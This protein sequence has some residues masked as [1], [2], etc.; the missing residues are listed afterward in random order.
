M[1]ESSSALQLVLWLEF[2][3]LVCDDLYPIFKSSGYDLGHGVPHHLR[4]SLQ[5]D[6]MSKPVIA[7][8]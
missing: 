5:A 4:I 8:G 3:A 6:Q 2:Q 7:Q 1:S